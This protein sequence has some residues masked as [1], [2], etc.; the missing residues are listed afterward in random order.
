MRLQGQQQEYIEPPF[1]EPIPTEEIQE[2]LQVTTGEDHVAQGIASEDT[3]AAIVENRRYHVRD[4]K[5]P[6]WYSQFVRH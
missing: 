4:R 5:G 3:P 2:P 6:D 1:V